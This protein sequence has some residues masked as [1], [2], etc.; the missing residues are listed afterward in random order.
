MF[1][2]D[3][4]IR[5]S[6]RLTAAQLRCRSATP[7][8]SAAERDVI[9]LQKVLALVTDRDDSTHLVRPELFIVKRQTTSVAADWLYFRS[10]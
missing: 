5:C 3:R 10:K 1:N 4:T 2:I 7:L 8:P 9:R 6:R